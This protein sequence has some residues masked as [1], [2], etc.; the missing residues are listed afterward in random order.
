MFCEGA[1]SWTTTTIRGE[2]HPEEKDRERV[3]DCLSLGLCH[4]FK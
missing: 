2:N 1:G 4:L 3:L